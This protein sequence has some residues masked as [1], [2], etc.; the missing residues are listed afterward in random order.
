MF[1]YRP[2]FNDNPSPACHPNWYR[3]LLIKADSMPTIF[4]TTRNASLLDLAKKMNKKEISVYDGLQSVLRL[5]KINVEFGEASFRM[6][7]GQEVPGT[8]RR[9]GSLIKY[10]RYAFD[11]IVYKAQR[12]PAPVIAAAREL[13]EAVANFRIPK[14]K[15]EKEEERVGGSDPEEEVGKEDVDDIGKED[16]DDVGKEDVDDIGKEDVDDI[17]ISMERGGDVY[18]QTYG[19]LTDEEKL[20]V[21]DY[22][23]MFNNK[24]EA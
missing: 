3:S 12:K 11:L 6:E 16:V 10:S 20:L 13:D 22:Y 15:G 23:K 17:G 7:E 2:Q 1:I 21:E 24:R 4:N 9:F 18:K 8:V 5:E 14:Q 19:E